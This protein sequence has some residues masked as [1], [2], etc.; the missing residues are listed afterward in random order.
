VLLVA[1]VVACRL[2]RRGRIFDASRVA[3][4]GMIAF[5]ALAAWLVMPAIEQFK[6]APV[7]AR[8]IRAQT[9]DDVPVYTLHFGEPSL[10]FY[11][12][13]PPL[14]TLGSIERMHEWVSEPGPAVLVTRREYVDAYEQEYGA[15]PLTV[16]ATGKGLNPAKGAAVDLIA[17]GRNLP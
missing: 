6:P 11:V 15:S 14:I 7:I 4:G 8:A 2:Q 3:L 17:L 9:G 10:V 16:I 1:V 12:G 13:R 5:M